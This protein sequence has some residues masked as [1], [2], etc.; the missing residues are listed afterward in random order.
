MV[1]VIR[2]KDWGE[3]FFD[4][5]LGESC[6]LPAAAGTK[7]TDHFRV[8]DKVSWITVAT[9]PEVKITTYNGTIVS[10]KGS[11][12]EIDSPQFETHQQVSLFELEVIQA[13]EKEEE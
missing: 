8:G 1:Q 3:V 12:A 11:T 9:E 4:G 6:P 7:I 13:A 10:I 2:H 5:D